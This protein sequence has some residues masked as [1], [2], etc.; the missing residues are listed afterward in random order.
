MDNYENTCI[1]YWNEHNFKAV[2]VNQQTSDHFK[3]SQSQDRVSWD[4]HK[5]IWK[6]SSVRSKRHDSE[7]KRKHLQTLYKNKE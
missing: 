5:D 2:T 4:E 1:K 3:L 7:N 6:S